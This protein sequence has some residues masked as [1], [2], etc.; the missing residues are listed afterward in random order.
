MVDRQQAEAT[1]EAWVRNLPRLGSPECVL[2]PEKTLEEPF[3]WVFFYEPRE[4]VGPSGLNA[5]IARPAP[6]L[7]LRETGELRIL[8]TDLPLENYL[9]GYRLS[10]PK[11][12]D[13]TWLGL[14]F[15]PLVIAGLAW[16]ASAIAR[17]PPSGWL[18]IAIGLCW[19]WLGA[20]TYYDVGGVGSWVSQEYLR[21]RFAPRLGYRF[22][23]MFGPGVVVFGAAWIV[24]GLAIL[25]GRG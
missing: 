9:V 2:R 5:T 13:A 3:G 22:A 16:F 19:A 10:L 23:R 17:Q 15:G 20:L 14:A 24:F 6:L 21:N 1:A 4:S 11:P 8:G 25:L 7:V 18:V 12:V